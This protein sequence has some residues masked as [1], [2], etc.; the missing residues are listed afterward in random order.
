MKYLYRR[1]IRPI[2]T[3][4]DTPHAVALGVWLGM[5]IGFSPTVG[6]QLILVAII[7]TFIRAN[8]IIALILCWVSNPVTF[9]P[10]Y[11]GYYW[12]GAKIMGISA[13]EVWT[14]ANFSR[15]I[16][17]FILEM[18]EQGYLSSIARLGA[19]I[20]EPLV[21]GSFLVAIVIST[22]LYPL[23]RY[24]LARRKRKDEER[25]FEERLARNGPDPDV[26]R[27]ER[28][29][30]DEAS[31][32]GIK[33]PGQASLRAAASISKGRSAAGGKVAGPGWAPKAPDRGRHE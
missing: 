16:D 7:G 27:D 20:L 33:P 14:F 3:I 6:F 4:N 10:M 22:P 1:F 2:F 25:A 32:P 8:R 17:R 11:Y 23:T 18:S 24:F 28:E 15:K 21:L 19:E 12:L 30:G 9:I 5:F 31:C 13:E 26:I 29:E